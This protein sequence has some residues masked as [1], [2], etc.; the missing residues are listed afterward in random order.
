MP[1]LPNLYEIWPWL[2]VLV[3]GSKRG[4]SGKPCHSRLLEDLGSQ[5]N[6]FHVPPY[7]LV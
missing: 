7:P 2:V 3:G 5:F 4:L 1:V 6:S